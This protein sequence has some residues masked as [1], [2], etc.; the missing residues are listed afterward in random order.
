M[1][2]GAGAAGVGAAGVGP[3]VGFGTFPISVTVLLSAGAWILS[4]R[5]IPR[6]CGKSFS[7]WS[8]STLALVTGGN[9]PAGFPPKLG[10]GFGV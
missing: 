9:T 2:V 8:I 1:G 5:V 4:G 3:G 10:G 7:I 6:F